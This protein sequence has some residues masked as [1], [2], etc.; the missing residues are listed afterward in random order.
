MLSRRRSRHRR[1]LADTVTRL[2]T[3]RRELLA[4]ITLLRHHTAA[5][6]RE[7]DAQ[8]DIIAAQGRQLLAARRGPL[9]DEPTERLP[10]V[11]ATVPLPRMRSLTPAGTVLPFPSEEWS[12]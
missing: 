1:D 4:E 9:G 8:R 5:V 2:T 3:E 7:N 10:R 6:T 11:T 12:R